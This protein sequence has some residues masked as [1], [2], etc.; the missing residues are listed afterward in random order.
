MRCIKLTIAYEGTRFSGWQRQQGQQ[1]VQGCVEAAW[2]SITGEDVPVTGSSRTD[3]GVH[4][5]AQ[6]AAVKTETK[7]ECNKIK[8]GLN[9][10]LPE[11][12]VI[13]NAEE[14]SLD[15][16]VISDTKRKRYKYQIHNSRTRRVFGRAFF[17][18]VPQELNVENMH[19]A[20]QALVGKHDFSSFESVGSPRDSSVRTIFDAVVY[21][22]QGEESEEIFI[23]IEGDG[24][25]YNM[26]RAIA[27]T[28]YKVG[29]GLRTVEWMTEVVEAKDRCTAGETAPA[30]GLFLI[31]IDY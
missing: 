27:G 16:D 3:A 19:A 13:L 22:G 28:L 2:K 15:F 1:T 20:A 14:A 17:W 26:V 24:F 6:A 25:L 7:I 12:I 30:E 4:A 18:Y 5:L 31:R 21:R 10:K 8:R 11:E 23:E 29:R 9:A